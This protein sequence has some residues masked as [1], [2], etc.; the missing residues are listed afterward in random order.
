MPAVE[1]AATLLHTLLKVVATL[2]A[3][4]DL[5]VGCDRDACVLQL[6]TGTLVYCNLCIGVHLVNE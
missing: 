2:D 1:P 3:S 6:V 5:K 4:G